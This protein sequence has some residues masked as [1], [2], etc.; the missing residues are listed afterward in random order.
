MST[1]LQMEKK[2]SVNTTSRATDDVESGT[3]SQITY[4]DPE[5][6]KAAFRKFD[7]YV[8]PASFIFMVLCALDRNNVRLL[9]NTQRSTHH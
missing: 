2:F 7:K 3:L 8:V 9:S 6:E 4:T 5:K 1:S